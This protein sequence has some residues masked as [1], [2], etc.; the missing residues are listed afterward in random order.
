MPLRTFTA[1]DGTT[2][3]AWNVV[4]TLARH[5]S[6]LAVGLD[7]TGGWLCFECRGVKRR[8]VPCPTG[9]DEWS[10][11][12]LQAALDAARPVERRVYVGS[13]LPHAAA[14]EPVES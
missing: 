3:N 4:P 2:W 13:I 14:P 5:G 1:G 9:W 7:M 10:D 11:A 12:E 6:R 8:I